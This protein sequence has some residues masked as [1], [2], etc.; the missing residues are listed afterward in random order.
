MIGET[1]DNQCDDANRACPS[2]LDCSKAD[3]TS[4]A[5]LIQI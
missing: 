5:S 4:A 1:P 3:A 2:S